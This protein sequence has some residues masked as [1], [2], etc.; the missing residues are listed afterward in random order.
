MCRI[1]GILNSGRPIVKIEETV[2]Q[3]CNLQKHGGPDD[4]G[5]YFSIKCKLVLGN[6]RLSLLDLTKA[7]HMPMHYKN[8]YHITYN[9]E[10]YN[11]KEIK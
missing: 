9:G 10:I 8:R 1:A 7:G 6:R 4:F 5:L 3:M 11:F 2:S